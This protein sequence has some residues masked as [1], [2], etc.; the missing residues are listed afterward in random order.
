MMAAIQ[1]RW[2]RDVLAAMI[3]SR[4]HKRQGKAVTNFEARLPAPQSDLA[5]QSLRDPYIFDFLTLEE[6]FHERE[7]ETGLIRHLEKFL[8]E[9]GRGFAF[10]GRQVN[11]DVGEEDFYMDLLFYHL[12]LRAF[13]WVRI[14]T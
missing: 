12:K 10:V 14:I 9:L 7:M 4:A 2:S 1:E 5:R 3:K 6:P 11:L 13:R 8:L